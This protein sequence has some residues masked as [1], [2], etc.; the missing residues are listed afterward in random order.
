MEPEIIFWTQNFYTWEQKVNSQFYTRSVIMKQGFFAFSL[1]SLLTLR[2]HLYLKVLG[3]IVIPSLQYLSDNSSTYV[4]E[5]NRKE[6]TSCEL[7][8]RKMHAKLKWCQLSE[9]NKRHWKSNKARGDNPK[10][11]N[12]LNA[13]IQKKKNFLYTG[14]LIFRAVADPRNSGISTKSREIPQK[15]RNTAQSARNIS[16]YMSAKHI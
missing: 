15:T 11:W 7:V 16:K 8:Y 14:L 4:P 9:R 3:F 5:P 6:K 13:L 10:L 1:S 2:N 12:F